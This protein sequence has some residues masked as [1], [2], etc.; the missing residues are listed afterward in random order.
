MKA[1]SLFDPKLGTVHVWS[2]D[3]KIPKAVADLIDSNVAVLGHAH[4]DPDIGVAATVESRQA[5]TWAAGAG[6]PRGRFYVTTGSDGSAAA[7]SAHLVGARHGVTCLPT[8]KSPGAGQWLREQIAQR[9][10][11]GLDVMIV[12]RGGAY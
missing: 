2:K 10:T 8:K 1:P 7:T 12:V 3:G 5:F 9:V 4:S 11:A 6:M